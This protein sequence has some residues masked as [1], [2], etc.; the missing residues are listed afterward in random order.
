MLVTATALALVVLQGSGDKPKLLL[1]DLAA[2][3]G[4]DASVASGLTRSIAVELTR[5]GVHDLVTSAD[6]VTLLGVERQKQL[7]G[8][9]EAQSCFAELS[10]ALG[11]RFVMT[12]GITR[13]GSAWQLTLQ[14]V[15]STNARAVGRAVQLAPDVGQL[16]E[17]VPLLVADAAGLPR[18]KEPSRIGPALMAGGGFAVLV[19]GGGI[20]L[21]SIFKENEVTR[22]LQLAQ[23]TPSLLRPAASYDSDAHLVVTE[24]VIAGVTL[25]V[26]AALAAGG[27]LW[28]WLTG[29]SPTAVALAPVPGGAAFAFAGSWP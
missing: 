5:R 2:G 7:M 18:P 16:A 25:G 20:L 14:T 17:A 13:M 3:E 24:R 12:G 11:T 19:A 28:L 21:T 6:V 1:Q 9:E 23:S 22:E 29:S 15:D 10:G 27:L 26:G 4:V 8:C